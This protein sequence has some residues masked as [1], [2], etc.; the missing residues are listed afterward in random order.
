V[1][2]VTRMI[3]GPTSMA[4]V[5]ALGCSPDGAR[6]APDQPASTGEEA[7]VSGKVMIKGK[8][9]TKGKVTIEPP[10]VKGKL[11]PEKIV[12]VGKDGTYQAKTYVG[13]N[14]F[15]VSG[16]GVA[17]AES[18]GTYNKKSVEIKSGA[19]PVDLDLPLDKP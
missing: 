7:T 13:R 9:A 8:P 2:H 18:A 17:E 14:S 3:F 12:E 5:L 15:T 6:P 11:M 4:L 16:T 10:Y 19:N 1:R